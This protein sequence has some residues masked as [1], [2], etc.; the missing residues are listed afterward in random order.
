MKIKKITDLASNNLTDLNQ[1]FKIAKEM[2][3]LKFLNL[4]EN[5]FSKVDVNKIEAHEL[6]NIKSL[7]NFNL[8]TVDLFDLYFSF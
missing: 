6:N 5:D 4:S 2:P 1:I 7:G 8:L 3:F